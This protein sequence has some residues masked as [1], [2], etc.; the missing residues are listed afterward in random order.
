[1]RAMASRRNPRKRTL[2]FSCRIEARLAMG[3][4]RAT[5]SDGASYQMNAGCD[6]LPCE[7]AV[8]RCIAGRFICWPAPR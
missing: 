2:Y 1:M 8:P 5:I 3:A 6:H 4:E 7:A